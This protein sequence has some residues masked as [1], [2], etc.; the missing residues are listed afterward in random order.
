MNSLRPFAAAAAL[1]L[2]VSRPWRPRPR[3]LRIAAAVASCVRLRYAPTTRVA[4]STVIL[5]IA[6][7]TR[8]DLS[9]SG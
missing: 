8:L 2:G 9:S 1:V 6:Q 4:Y 5:A 3:W 7:S